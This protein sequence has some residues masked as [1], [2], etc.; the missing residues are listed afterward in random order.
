MQTFLRIVLPLSKAVLASIGLM[1]TVSYWNDYTNY[2]LYIVNENLN[3][4]QMKLRTIM[5]ASGL[6]HANFGA[7]E[8]TVRNAAIIIAI[9]PFMVLY[10]TLQKYFVKGIIIGAVKE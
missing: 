7:S 4:F 6:P 9:L 1:F 8:N 3:N 10:P 2:Q 5:M